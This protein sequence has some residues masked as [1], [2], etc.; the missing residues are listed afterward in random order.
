[1]ELSLPGIC[2]CRI[3]RLPN[4]KRF[5]QQMKVGS[6]IDTVL[7]WLEFVRYLPS[8]RDRESN[9]PQQLFHESMICGIARKRMSTCPM[10]IVRLCSRFRVH[11]FV[12]TKRGWVIENLPSCL[13]A[14]CSQ[15]LNYQPA[16]KDDLF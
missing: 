15:L 2:I 4:G 12:D 10:A 13:I 6:S 11:I 8:I 3:S 9:L 7:H 16:P 14:D 1:M 5:L